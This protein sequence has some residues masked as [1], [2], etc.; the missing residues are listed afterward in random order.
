MRSSLFWDVTQRRLVL[1]YRRFGTKYRSRFQ[2]P[3]DE[4]KNS[5]TV[6]HLKIGRIDRPETFVIT[7]LRASIRSKN[8][9]YYPLCWIYPTCLTSYFVRLSSQKRVYIYMSFEIFTC[10]KCNTR[11]SAVGC[12]TALQVGRSR[13]RLPMV[14]LGFF[15]DIIL[16]AALWPWGWFSL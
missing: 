14:S 6:W 8:S 4:P 10:F 11:C 13:V 7:N 15:I 16:L 9:A 12:G 1:S 3:V 2:Q 5:W